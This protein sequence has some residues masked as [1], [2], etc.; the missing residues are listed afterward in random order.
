M[1]QWDVQLKSAFDETHRIATGSVLL[2]VVIV[3]IVVAT[4]SAG[5]VASILSLF[6]GAA[7]VWYVASYVPFVQQYLCSFLG[8]SATGASATG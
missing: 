7:I 4:V 6:E 2:S 1:V 3:L 5:I 8:R